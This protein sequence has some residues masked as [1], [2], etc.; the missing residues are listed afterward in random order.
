MRFTVLVLAAACADPADDP[1]QV[2]L[3]G[4][5]PPG[6]VRPAGADVGLVPLFG[7]GIAATLLS[8]WILASRTGRIR[9]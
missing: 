6:T 8:N 5:E 3:L 4:S 9:V 2:A 1:T 7:G